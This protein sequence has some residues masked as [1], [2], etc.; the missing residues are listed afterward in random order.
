MG[1]LTLALPSVVPVPASATVGNP[2]PKDDRQPSEVPA[3]TGARSRTRKKKKVAVPAWYKVGEAN[4]GL[5][6]SPQKPR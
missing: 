3:S 2:I 4:V 1:S 6:I 5:A